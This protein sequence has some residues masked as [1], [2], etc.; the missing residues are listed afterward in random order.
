MFYKKHTR[1]ALLKLYRARDVV[2]LTKKTLSAKGS[3]ALSPQKNY[4]RE[5]GLTEI[6][7]LLRGCFKIPSVFFT[8]SKFVPHHMI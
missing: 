6:A 5:E 4:F 1:G 8:V 7:P 3:V 2:V